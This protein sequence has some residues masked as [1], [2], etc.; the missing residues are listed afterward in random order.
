MKH[1]VSH[2]IKEKKMKK[3]KYYWKKKEKKVIKVEKNHLKMKIVVR[4]KE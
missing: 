2:A 3:K 4:E 1:I